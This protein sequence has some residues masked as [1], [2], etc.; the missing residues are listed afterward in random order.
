MDSD[1]EIGRLIYCG[2]N[3]GLIALSLYIRRSMFLIFGANGVFIYLGHLAYEVF[4]D[5]VLFPFALV[6]LGLAMIVA[7]VLAQKY[8]NPRSE[9]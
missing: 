4:K 9:K 3:I 2:I 8:L 1:S 7:T 5:S 6:F